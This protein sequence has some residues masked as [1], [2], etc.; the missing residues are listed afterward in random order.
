MRAAGFHH[1]MPLCHEAVFPPIH[2]DST[3]YSGCQLSSYLIATK[4]IKMHIDPAPL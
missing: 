1:S 4:N 3:A 2:S